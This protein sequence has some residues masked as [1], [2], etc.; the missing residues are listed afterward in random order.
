MFSLIKPFFI[1]FLSFSSSL[2]RV[3]KVRTKLMSLNY[4]P[5]IVMSYHQKYNNK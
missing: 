1:V 3:A 4:E 5:C 2:A